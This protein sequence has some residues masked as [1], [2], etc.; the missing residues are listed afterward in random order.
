[1]SLGFLFPGQGSQYLGMG[2]DLY[3]NFPEARWVY[4]EAVAILGVD[5]KSLSFFGPEEELRKTYITQPAIL[6]HSIAVLEILRNKDIQ[7]EIAF[8]HSLG[9]YTALYSAGVFDFSSVLKIVQRRGELMYAEG[10]KNPGTMAAIIGLAEEKVKEICERTKGIVV[11]A[12]FNAP[13]QIVISGEIE[14]VQDAGEAAKR[15]G[16][17]KV[18]PLPVSGAF[19]SPLL[20]NSGAELKEFL[21]GF[22]FNEPLFPVIMSNGNI[23][24]NSSE[25]KRLL[26]EQLTSPVLFTRMVQRAK[27]KGFMRFLEVGP[28]KVLQGLIKRIDKELNVIPTGKKEEIERIT[29]FGER[30]QTEEI[31]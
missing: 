31:S 29:A 18:I 25:I 9:E 19:H 5:I 14:A 27:E 16:A 8:G 26:Y 2:K 15:E 20:K 7:P 28:G 13:D 12:N 4:D 21:K 17:L 23:A 3:E 6:V 30:R 1:M 11:P 24:I 22:T 10:E